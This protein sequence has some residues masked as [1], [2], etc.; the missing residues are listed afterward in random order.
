MRQ[1]YKR[2][3]AWHEVLQNFGNEEESSAKHVQDLMGKLSI[4]ES[5]VVLFP[6]DG[7]V[8]GGDPQA[9]MQYIRDLLDLK[10]I[11]PN[12]ITKYSV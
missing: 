2:G 11:Y 1:G 12:T 8:C 5:F 3:K 7:G 6:R 9:A 10:E 4:F